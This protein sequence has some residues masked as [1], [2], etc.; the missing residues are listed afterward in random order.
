MYLS[1][2]RCSKKVCST[3]GWSR[4][5]TKWNDDKWVWLSFT[6]PLT[7]MDYSTRK[8]TTAQALTDRQNSKKM[9]IQRHFMQLSI[10]S[11]KS[12]DFSR[13][14][15]KFSCKLKGPANSLIMFCSTAKRQ[16]WMAISNIFWPLYSLGA[17]LYYARPV[18]FLAL[19]YS[20]VLW[21]LQM[22]IS[23]INSAKIG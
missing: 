22:L 18:F 17:I 12:P 11:Q 10:I 19:I 5:P 13:L 20:F 15:P 3:L 6:M 7:A 4:W 2:W 16:F 8:N 14:T 1:R 21:T 23:S 9:S